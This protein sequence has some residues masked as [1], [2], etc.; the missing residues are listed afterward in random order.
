MNRFDSIIHTHSIVFSSLFYLIFTETAKETVETTFQKFAERDDVGL[1]IMNQ[2]IADSIRPV[3]SAHR[4]PIP[5]VIE[6][7]SKDSPMNASTDPIMKRV[8][9]ML[10]EI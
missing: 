8:L 7:P 10:G 3:I 5:M 1:I 4:A 9:Q 2:T 6:I